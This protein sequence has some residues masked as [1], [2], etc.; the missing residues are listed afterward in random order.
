MESSASEPPLWI[1]RDDLTGAALSGNKI[2][3][4]EFLVADALRVGATTLVTCGGVQSN[5]AR[6]TAIAAARVGLDSTLVLRGTGKEPMEGNLFLDHLLGAR[7]HWVTPEQYADIDP[8]FE[9]IATAL[10]EEGKVPYIIPEGGSNALGAL[11]YLEATRE[12]TSQLQTEDLSFS[13]LFVAVGSGGTLAG[14]LAGWA[15]NN[16]H[17][18]R[19][20]GIN[21]CDTAEYFVDRV[22][23]ILEEMHARWNI[24]RPPRSEI[25]LLDGYVGR[26][27]ALS[28]QEELLTIQNVAR[29]D[30]VVL[31][32]VY[33]GKAF[34]ACLEFRQ[35]RTENASAL[36]FWHTGGI[37]GLF[38]K[39]HEAP[40]N[41]S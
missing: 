19:P 15:E 6:A 30:G 41:P 4:L 2:R 28:T 11:G 33:S 36:L 16:F 27:Y 22:D 40:W 3:K 21:V 9:T 10:R 12:L 32:P 37:F 8:V 20:I 5:H 29:T 35:E 25:H 14:L 26:G 23:G 18:P 31:D 39:A 38:P 17:G 13:H 7:I 34:G 24:P 1:K